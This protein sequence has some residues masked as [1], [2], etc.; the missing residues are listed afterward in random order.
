MPIRN[1]LDWARLVMIEATGY[2]EFVFTWRR[3]GI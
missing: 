2:Q 3:A 1:L